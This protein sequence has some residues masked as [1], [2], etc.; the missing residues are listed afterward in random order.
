MSV[1]ATIMSFLYA[2]IGLGLS[3]AKATGAAL[4]FS[5]PHRIYSG[6][7][8]VEGTRCWSTG[9]ACSQLVS[10][11]WIAQSTPTAQ[12]RWEASPSTTTPP[13]PTTK[14]GVSSRYN[15]CPNFPQS[16]QIGC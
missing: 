2:T 1:I 8:I 7:G 9:Q 15:C 11:V 5:L 14:S 3:I 13:G 12:E 4:T 6:C 16:T 10:S